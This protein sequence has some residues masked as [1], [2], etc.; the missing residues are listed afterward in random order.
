MEAG[1]LSLF[2]L[3]LGHL[4]PPA[5]RL[6][7]VKSHAEA[8]GTKINAAGRGHLETLTAVRAGTET[9]SSSSSSLGGRVRHGDPIL[10]KHR[11]QSRAEQSCGFRKRM[12][13]PSLTQRQEG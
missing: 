9:P 11:R 2:R 1:R 13:D 8:A 7:T 5:A 3:T 6:D 10:S 4:K 12:D